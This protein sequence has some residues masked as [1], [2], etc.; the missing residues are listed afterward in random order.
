MSDAE[1]G[2]QVPPML[3]PGGVS[4]QPTMLGKAQGPNGWGIG[5][6]VVT[7]TL[8][9]GSGYSD[10]KEGAQGEVPGEKGCRPRAREV[11]EGGKPRF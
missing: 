5:D 7:R 9:G 1:V 8:Y 2:G 6:P 4:S 11:R 3:R 10:G